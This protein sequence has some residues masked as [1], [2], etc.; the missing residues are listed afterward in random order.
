MRHTDE[1]CEPGLGLLTRSYSKARRAP[2]PPKQRLVR[3][4]PRQLETTPGVKLRAT[5]SSA[6]MLRA[7]KVVA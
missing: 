2:L 1:T 5:L 7:M 6:G 3:V 4:G